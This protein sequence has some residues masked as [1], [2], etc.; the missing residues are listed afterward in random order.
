VVK[1]TVPLLALVTLAVLVASCM[2][3]VAPTRPAQAAFPGQN[4]KI[5]FVDRSENP[6]HNL[7]IYTIDPTDPVDHEP[8]LLADNAIEPAF[9]PD[10]EK[11]AFER[12]G[13]VWVMNADGSKQVQLTHSRGYT[14]KPSWFPGGRKIAVLSNRG[15][16]YDA[17]YILTLNV[18]RTRVVGVEPLTER[19]SPKTDLAVSPSG[20]KIA[21]A[22]GWPWQA[23][24]HHFY[25]LRI[26]PPV[27]PVLVET[28]GAGAPR[29]LDWSPNGKK[30]V[31]ANY[32]TYDSP[33]DLE[34]EYGP[35]YSISSR[36]HNLTKLGGDPWTTPHGA[37]VYSPDGRQI[38]F[39]YDHNIWRMKSN[40]T[41]PVQLTNLESDWDEDQ[42]Y[43]WDFDWQA[44]P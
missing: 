27:P 18:A 37:P 19:G 12:G 24:G 14:S 15:G 9:S 11:L 16:S 30:I 34:Y 40:G 8:T 41:E 36:G 21:Y 28:G 43:W 13:Q 44:L 32:W 25:V 2:A 22:T 7:A 10:G 29:N 39:S 23:R 3:L 35:I 6:D 31:F 4:G 1:K 20:D 5:A 38:A 33:G 17:I 26:D 42:V